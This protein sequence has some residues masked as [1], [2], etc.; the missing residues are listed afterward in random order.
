MRAGSLHTLRPYLAPEWPALAVAM[1]STT[2]VV[3][4]WLA[5]PLPL[6]LVVDQIVQGRSAPFELSL[7]TNAPPFSSGNG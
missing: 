4:A 5:R 6:A 1:L 3:L 2:A 7:A